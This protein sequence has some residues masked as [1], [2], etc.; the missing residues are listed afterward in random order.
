MPENKTF[1]YS[2]SE[3]MISISEDHV[4]IVYNMDHIVMA[5]LEKSG[6]KKKVKVHFIGGVTEVLEPKNAD[7]W[8]RMIGE[9]FSESDG[10]WYVTYTE[11]DGKLAIIDYKK[12]EWVEVSDEESDDETD[13]ESDED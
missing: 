3:K 11:K 2:R 8:I 13:E 7:L 9:P 1:R 4:H 12:D 5:N 6:G 10:V